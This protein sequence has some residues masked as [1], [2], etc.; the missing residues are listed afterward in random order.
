MNSNYNGKLTISDCDDSKNSIW[1]IPISGDGFYKSLLNNLCLQ[2]SN[3]N[4]GT[5]VMSDCNPNSVIYDINNTYNGES[6][7]SYLD[8]DKCLGLFPSNRSNEN[9]LN[10]N[11]CDDSMPDQH[12]EI[13]VK[14]GRNIGKCPYGQCC[15]KE[16][17]CGNT[18]KYCGAD[19]QSEFGKCNIIST[20]TT[21][22][23][24]TN[25]T[26]TS[27]PVWIYNEYT[28]KCLHAPEYI[29]E[30]LIYKK[31]DDTEN[32]Q[33]YVINTKIGSYFKSKSNLNLCMRVSDNDNSKLLM[34]ECDENAILRYHK[35]DGTIV[36][37][38]SD[39]LCLG[40]SVNSVSN[41]SSKVSNKVKLY[42]CDDE[43]HEDQI[44][45]ILNS[46]PINKVTTTTTTT[47]T[48][49]HTTT[50]TRKITTTTT[51]TTTTRTTTTTTTTTKTNP[52]TSKPSPTTPS[53]STNGKCGP[54]ANGTICP[55]G[56]CC[57]KY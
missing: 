52:T 7:T 57:S 18:L 38:L 25:P 12:W 51:T 8:E 11:I 42:D 22:A 3:I 15:S 9:C 24:T 55:T 54:K 20:T 34:G 2:V 19:C 13:I 23:T 16:G 41:K 14:C 44:W 43:I 32:N 21:I 28:N 40:N 56:K 53:F 36:S 48:T 33:W 1:Q 45:I 5:I 30:S 49:K 27:S 26:P 17:T 6:I 50:T 39:S 37:K 10:L 46:K 35:N 29:D 47:T 31:C 4:K